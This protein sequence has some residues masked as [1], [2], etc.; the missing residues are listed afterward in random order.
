[1]GSTEGVS[2]GNIL[3]KAAEIFEGG[4]EDNRCSGEKR[5]EEESGADSDSSSTG[6]APPPRERTP[7]LERLGV[8][9]RRPRHL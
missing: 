2:P 3:S 7:S 4:T 8:P 9:G 5:G 1:M 6:V